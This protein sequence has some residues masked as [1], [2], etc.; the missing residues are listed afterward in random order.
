M[1]SQATGHLTSIQ[2]QTF[3]N[4]LTKIMMLYQ[5]FLAN[6]FCFVWNVKTKKNTKGSSHETSRRK[7]Y[8]AMLYV[9]ECGY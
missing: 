7:I 9:S 1:F 2:I 4:N 6:L 5:H 8:N 3:F